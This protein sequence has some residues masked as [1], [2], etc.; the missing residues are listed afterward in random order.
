MSN[1]LVVVKSHLFLALVHSLSIC[2]RREARRRQSLAVGLGRE[3]RL[4]LSIAVGWREAEGRPSV[5]HGRWALG[6]GARQRRGNHLQWALGGKVAA[7]TQA[8]GGG[9]RQ[10]L[11][12]AHVV[13]YTHSYAVSG[14]MLR[15]LRVSFP[16]PFFTAS[17]SY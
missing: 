16:F 5:N 13:C 8:L 4:Q 12:Y 7:V 10:G 11:G 6:K 15:F 2:I 14:Q 9:A 17:A 1:L 3:A